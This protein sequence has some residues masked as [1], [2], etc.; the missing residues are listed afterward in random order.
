MQKLDQYSIEN[1]TKNRGRA[2]VPKEDK[3]TADKAESEDK[4][5]PEPTKREDEE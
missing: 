2:V 5:E 3:E 4:T 1:L